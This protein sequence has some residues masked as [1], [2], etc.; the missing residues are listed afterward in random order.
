MRAAP[1]LDVGLDGNVGTVVGDLPAPGA[2]R[3][4]E[5]GGELTDLAGLAVDLADG[6]EILAEH[7]AGDDPVG[8][9]AL[10]AARVEFPIGVELPGLARQPGQ[11]AAFDRAVVE[12]QE[13][14]AG[15]GAQ[16]AARQAADQGERIA[17]LRQTGAIAGAHQ[18]DGLERN[19][20]I[21]TVEIMQLWS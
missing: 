4:A 14:M 2:D 21:V 20:E 13:L 12:D 17:V 6:V 16:C 8:L 15:G 1:L 18:L 19:A 3:T 11:H 7:L 10:V 5:A 9:D